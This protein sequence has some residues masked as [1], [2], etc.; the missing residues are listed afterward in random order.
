MR[1]TIWNDQFIAACFARTSFAFAVIIP[2]KTGAFYHLAANILQYP[3]N[4][5][6]WLDHAI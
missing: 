4:A 3:E 2:Y 1:E 5:R 6:A